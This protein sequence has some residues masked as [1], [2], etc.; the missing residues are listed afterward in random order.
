MTFASDWFLNPRF[1]VAATG[2]GVI[3][4]GE[5]GNAV[6][7]LQL[8]LIRLGYPLPGS[9]VSGGDVDGVFGSETD[10]RVREFQKASVPND[11]PDGKVGPKTLD[12]L[13][14]RLVGVRPPFNPTSNLGSGSLDP[15]SNYTEFDLGPVFG[16]LLAMRQPHSDACWATCL[17]F[18]AIVCGGSRM[19]LRTGEVIA[20]YAHLTSSSGDHMGGM[21]TKNLIR[22]LQD[23][24]I[25]GNMLT[26]HD[27][28]P[29]W[30]AF[31]CEPFDAKARLTYAWLKSNTGARRMMF[32]G[33]KVK[34]RAHINVISYYDFE[35]HPYVIA[36]EPASGTFKLRD[37]EYYQGSSHSLFAVPY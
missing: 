14:R 4:K 12:A 36:M 5:S 27:P 30:N 28:I 32:F 34:G 31:V 35:G 26:P 19:K 16:G 11:T 22:I 23:L 15:P 10:R 20:K 7:V 33:Y 13:D 6:K 25:P 29:K 24:E 9:T 37:I 17:A 21:P 18:W 1:A 3:K 2:A 8:A